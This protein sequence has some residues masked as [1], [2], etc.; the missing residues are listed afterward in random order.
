SFRPS[1]SGPREATAVNEVQRGCDPNVAYSCNTPVPRVCSPGNA[2][3]RV[4]PALCSGL[5]LQR[6]AYCP[7]VRDREF[8]FR[9]T[10]AAL[11]MRRQWF[12][13]GSLTASAAFSCLS[14][15]VPMCP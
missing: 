3:W 6:V 13:G 11:D 12:G 15:D 2:C 8:D 10:G 1:R 5:R 9:E 4:R 14:H 7:V